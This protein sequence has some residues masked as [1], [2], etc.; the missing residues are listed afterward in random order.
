MPPEP[1]PSRPAALTRR[2]LLATAAALAALPLPAAAAPP[3][4]LQHPPRQRLDPDQPR[5]RAPRHRCIFDTATD[6][7]AVGRRFDVCVIGVGPRR[8]HPGAPPRRRRRRR[9]ADGG[10]RPHLLRESQALY[11]G[12]ERRPRLLPPRRL[13]AALLRRHLEPLG[14]LV[15]RPRPGDFGAK[16]LQPAER[17]ADRQARPRPL[18]PRRPTRIL[19]L[20]PEPPLPPS[21]LPP[22]AHDFTRVQF[23]FSP[24]TRVQRQVRR[25]DRRLRPRSACSCI[26]NLVDLRLTDD[27]GAVSGGGVP[28]LRPRRPRLHR[29]A[30]RR[31]A[32]C[33][34]GIENAR[35]LLNFRSQVPEGIGN[36]HGM[37]GRCFAEHPHV[38]VADVLL[39]DPLG[40]REFF[41]AT[42]D[43]IFDREVLNFVVDIDGRDPAPP[44]ASTTPPS[45][46]SAATCPSST[47]WPSASPATAAAAPTPR[48][49]PGGAA[50][51][52]RRRWSA[53]TWSRRSTPRAGSI[54]PRPATPSACRPR[55]STGASPTSASTPCAPA[56][57]R[58][59]ITSPA[60]H[61]PR[62][63]PRLAARRAGGL[64]R[65]SPAATRSAGWHHMGTTRM[66]DDPRH[67]VVDARLPRPR[68]RQPLHRRLQRLRHRRL[69]QPRPTRSSSSPC[70]SA[71]TS[72]AGSPPGIE[73]AAPAHAPPPSPPAGA[74]R[75]HFAKKRGFLLSA[76]NA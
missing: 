10:R 40:S 75:Q 3:A 9:R 24:P 36:R 50:R 60:G 61:R 22:P 72:K 68:H 32:L 55:C 11:R 46:R 4:P 18:P 7:S 34:G 73:R 8:H 2:R 67:G 49:P 53:S 16:P 29:R 17:L 47:A 57:S 6:R 33:T 76:S 56:P 44:P 63:H 59:A 26:A 41:A 5:P 66:A 27:L 48:W 74:R 64:P 69:R 28:R 39:R 65:R 37:V 71:T 25:R 14:R 21:E 23:R 38:A 62:P 45:A 13:P 20:P 15:P 42:E 19:D 54:S 30:P 43:F 31:L 52:A 58:S 1:E 35:L 12:R 70:A 51:R